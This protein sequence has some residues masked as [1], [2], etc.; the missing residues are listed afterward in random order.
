VRICPKKGHLTAGTLE[1][2]AYLQP[3]YH[4]HII[5]NGFADIQEIKLNT[6]GIKN[7]FKHIITAEKAQFNKPHKGIFDYALSLSCANLSNSIMIG[8]E[9]HTDVAGAKDAGMDHIYY[10]P[11]KTPHDFKL[12]YEI[13]HIAELQNIL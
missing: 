10:N 9:L 11:T 7:Y 2:L 6:S 13:H 1:T 4:L 12:L 5:S 3:N 8:D